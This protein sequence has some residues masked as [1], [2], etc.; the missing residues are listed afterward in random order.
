MFPGAEASR[1]AAEYVIVGAPLDLS[2]SFRPG[3]RFGPDQLRTHASGFE[4]YDRETDT[5]FSTVGVHDHGNITPWDDVPAYLDYVAGV[6]TEYTNDGI[7]PML[8]GGEH[9]VSIAGVDALGPTELVCF[10]A[11]LD[12]RRSYNENPWSHATT[13]HHASERV[14]QM[15]IVGARSGSQSEWE[16]IAEAGITVI[17]PEQVDSWTPDVDGAV[18]LSLDMDVFDPAIAP[19]TGTPE[20]F[21]VPATLVREKIRS[22]APESVGFD[23][24]EVT[25]RD[26][27]QTATLAAKLLR[28]FVFA[29]ADAKG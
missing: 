8:L 15:T 19:A 25:D 13:L 11:H 20:P 28:E 10:D 16:R 6:L 26:T 1:S 29:H 4:D 17:E 14:D 21:G 27:G 2:A 3:A 5:Q 9:T 24:V 18:Y 22:I 23:I 7:V 12:L